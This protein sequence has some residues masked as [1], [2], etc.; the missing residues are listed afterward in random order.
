MASINE[1]IEV[2]LENVCSEIRG[3][4]KTRT[5]KRLFLKNYFLSNCNATTAAAASNISRRTIYAWTAKDS[6][7][8]TAMDQVEALFQGHIT[9]LVI[10]EAEQ[11]NDR[12]IALAARKMVPKF[13]DQPQ[14]EINNNLVVNPNR[15][16]EERMRRTVEV[17]EAI[18]FT[19]TD[20][21]VS[22]VI[23]G[24]VEGRKQLPHGK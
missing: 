11:G 18:G 23:E 16:H 5:N 20:K 4:K 15:S 8:A 1:E 21:S 19:V 17:M 9:G 7:F 6:T 2:Q 22:N 10:D 3:R 13:A 12:L 24:S 14:V